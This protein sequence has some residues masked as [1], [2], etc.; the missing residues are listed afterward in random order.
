MKKLLS[1]MLVIVMTLAL[2]AGC[3]GTGNTNDPVV[4]NGKKDEFTYVVNADIDDF[5]P[6]SSQTIQ[7]VY[8]FTF[9]CFEP[10]FHL[11]ENMEYEMDLAESYK[12]VDD[13]TYTFKLRE[14]VTFHNG[15]KFTAQDVI[16]TINYVKDASNGSYKQSSFANVA[17]MIAADDYNL[18]IKLSAPTP[19]FLDSLAW[20]AITSKSTDVAS[21]TTKPVGTGAFKFDS[22][23]PNDSIK[24]SKYEQY[25]DADK[26]NFNKVTIKPYTDYTL[27]VNGLYAGDVDYISQM[28]VEQAQSVDTTK[29]AK[30]I[31]AKSSNQTYL[32]EVGLHNV[33]AFKDPNVMKA[34]KLV[35]DK[36]A[37]NKSIYGGMGTAS[38]SVFPSGAKYHK[39]TDTDTYNL[40]EAKK[41]M[42]ASA[43]ANGFEFEVLVLSGDTNS[44]MACV[45]WQQELAKLGITMKINVCEMSIWLDAYLGRTY[46]MICNVYSMV[47]SD[48]ATFCTII[49]APYVD[50]QCKDMPELFQEIATGASSSDEAVRKAAYE[51]IQDIVSASCPAISYME[52]PQ[53][54][55]TASNVEGVTMNAMAHVFLKGAAKN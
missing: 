54:A 26:I 5:N 33:E 22:W 40:D 48:P 20:L 39:A 19:A 8:F 45:I 32:F 41:L 35:L 55:A 13:V 7:F 6:Y 23:T 2:F 30:V 42:A 17:E 37:I 14:G 44:E 21:L 24:L 29:N 11:N 10:L 27:A 15:E 18:T 53:V 47:G 49:L 12:Q 3:A 4:D 28:T 51:K 36:D 31:T 9:N 1:V 52:A 43:Y 16:H 46:D 25:W 34:M 50:Y 38:T